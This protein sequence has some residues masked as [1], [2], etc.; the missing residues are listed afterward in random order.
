MADTSRGRIAYVAEATF[1]TTPTDPTLQILRMLGSSLAY[2]KQTQE[3]NE[4]DSGAMITD[5]IEVGAESG[6]SINVEWSP[7]S[8]DAL[9]EAALRGTRSTATV[10]P[11]GGAGIV[12]STPTATVTD[13]GVFANVE[14]GQWLLFRG[15][16]NSGNNGWKKVVTNPD[17]DSITIT[18]TGMVTEAAGGTGQIDGQTILNGTT[19]RSFSLE[20]AFTDE[21]IYRLFVGQRVGSM[22]F[23]F[24]AGNILT[25]SI[26]FMGTQVSIED[27]GTGVDPSWLGSGSRTAATTTNVM[28]ATANVGGIYIDGSLSTACFKALSLNLDN[29]LR[30]TRCIGSKFPSVIGYGKQRVT[31]SL[32]K[33]FNSTTLYEAMLDDSTLSLSFGAYNTS[34][35][36]HIYLPKIK[37]GND[38]LSLSGG[39]DTDVD[40]G[41]DWTALKSD[42]GTHQIRVDIAT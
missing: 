37:L 26:G 7:D 9:I 6:G 32:T 36:I 19:E 20:E 1:G 10:S 8:Y 3:S 34:G 40:E 5:L 13:T 30:S 38:N 18:D 23:D 12:F 27:P 39:N 41:I 11:A 14:V 22:S 28:N 29:A 2:T 15:W 31:G 24:S 16:S 33:V 17:D 35:G 21:E 25:G 42:D 4:L